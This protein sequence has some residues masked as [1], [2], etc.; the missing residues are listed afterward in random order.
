VRRE[1]TRLQ[2]RLQTTVL[3]VTHDIA[4]AFVLGS[5]VG[6]L[7]AGELIAI[8]APSRIAASA[9]PRVRLLLDALPPLR[10]PDES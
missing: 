4:E 10:A 6:V 1:F 9:D 8:D 7:D 5:R 3:V 2:Q